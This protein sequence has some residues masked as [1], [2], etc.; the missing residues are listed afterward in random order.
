MKTFLL[1]FILIPFVAVAYDYP[2]AVTDEMFEYYK[3]LND[4][5]TNLLA[6]KDNDVMLR[7]K[8][9]QLVEI[10]K[11]RKA[12]NVQPVELDILASRV[13]N[14][15]CQEASENRYMGHWNL[16]GEKPYHRYARYGGKDHVMENAYAEWYESDYR[17]E[18]TSIQVQQEMMAAGHK[19]FMQ[20]KAPFDGHKQTVI[21]G[22]HNYVGIGCYIN[23]KQ[24]SYYEEFVDR[25]LEIEQETSEDGKIGTVRFKILDPEKFSLD[26]V[27]C[28]V[29]NIKPMSAMSIN[30]SSFYKDYGED[31]HTAFE[32]E[33]EQKDGWYEVSFELSKPGAFYVQVLLIPEKRNLEKKYGLMY[34]SGVVFFNN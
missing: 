31:H 4:A 27:S 15:I 26:Q 34:V 32:D 19:S 2:K 28:T 16:A 14:K 22:W 12:Y 33:L 1:F 17:F 5:D 20:E 30:K 23:G 25:Y 3:A 6:F 9:Y 29:D 21:A 24:F 11:S 8:L 10:N 18:D 7:A 13:A